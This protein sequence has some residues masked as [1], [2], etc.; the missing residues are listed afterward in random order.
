M[1]GSGPWAAA[2]SHSETQA[3]SVLGLYLP[4]GLQSSLLKEHIGEEGKVHMGSCYGS[5]LEALPVLICQNSVMCP[6]N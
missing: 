4:A 3:P 5:S 2:H 6:C 1:L